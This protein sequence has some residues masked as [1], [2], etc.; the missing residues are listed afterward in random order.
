MGTDGGAG[1]EEASGTNDGT[2]A[3]AGERGDTHR[4]PRLAVASD[5]Y[6]RDRMLFATKL[7][8]ARLHTH[9]ITGAC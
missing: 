2:P 8:R 3:L 7:T 5:A 6:P 9:D 4:L 1:A